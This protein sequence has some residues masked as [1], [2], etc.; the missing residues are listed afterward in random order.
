MARHIPKRGGWSDRDRVGRVPLKAA[1]PALGSRNCVGEA[2][3]SFSRNRFQPL[4]LVTQ[5]RGA[6]R[7]GKKGTEEKSAGLYHLAN[8]QTSS[9]T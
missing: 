4:P 1:A 7:S 8:K 9:M 2:A 3:F 5:L 6:K